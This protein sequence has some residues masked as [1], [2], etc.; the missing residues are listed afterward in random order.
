MEV[1]IKENIMEVWKDINGYEDLYQISNYGNVYS[2]IKQ[3]MMK[4][5]DNK[6][7]LR[8]S[9]TKNGQRKNKL[10]HVLVCSHFVGDKPSEIH[11]VN[12][13][14]LNKKNNCFTNLEWVLPKENIAHAIENIHNREIYLKETMSI[15]GKNYCKI[16]IDA[17]KK[18]VVQIDRTTNEIL[19]IY[20]SARE[21]TKDGFNYRNISQVCLHEKKSHKGFIWRFLSEVNMDNIKMEELN[22]I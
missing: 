4:P 20:E 8:I 13:K 22:G 10:I 6:G 5:F 9:L 19:R 16:G 17:S 14:D 21:A 2:I 7:Y 3:T 18:S 1:I 12:H 11:E 15:I